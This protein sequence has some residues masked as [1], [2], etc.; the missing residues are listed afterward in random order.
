M[1]IKQ[2]MLTIDKS[3]MRANEAHNEGDRAKEKKWLT[4]AETCANLIAEWE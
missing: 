2:L 3:F 1:S 4:V